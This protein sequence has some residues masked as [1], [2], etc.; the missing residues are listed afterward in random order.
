MA[1]V[2]QLLRQVLV[3]GM[4]VQKAF[5]EAARDKILEELLQKLWENASALDQETLS[6]IKEEA[7]KNNIALH[8]HKGEKV[9]NSQGF[10]GIDEIAKKNEHN[11]FFREKVVPTL[12]KENIAIY[13][14]QRG[15]GNC[16]YRSFGV[17]YINNLL[18]YNQNNSLEEL[19]ADY[20]KQHNYIVENIKDEDLYKDDTVLTPREF[21][22][23]MEMIRN[24]GKEKLQLLYQELNSAEK[25]DEFDRSIVAYIRSKLAQ[26]IDVMIDSG[27][28]VTLGGQPIEWGLDGFDFD[29]YNRK[30][31]LKDYKD[32]IVNKLDRDFESQFGHSILGHIFGIDI[33]SFFVDRG[34]P[35]KDKPPTINIQN[36][37]YDNPEKDFGAIDA[38][39][40]QHR[41]VILN[42]RNNET[43]EQRND[44]VM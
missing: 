27:N 6:A 29:Q 13:Q 19:I 28:S 1:D 7:E 20:E 38:I 41:P 42:F 34:D 33:K 32:N 14:G 18:V 11:D 17:G 30:E 37:N 25:S 16:F 2:Q 12:D 3:R 10:T 21:K 5:Q 8:Q 31:V 40:M 36:A 43:K 39:K 23:K 24:G 9:Q 4:T 44:K 35:S 15:D 22:E 26:S